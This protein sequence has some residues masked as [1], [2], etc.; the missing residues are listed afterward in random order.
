MSQIRRII[1]AALA[2]AACLAQPARAETSH[3]EQLWINL[4]AM[5]SIS[6]RAVYFVEFQPRIGDG[7]SRVDQLLM[8]AALGWKLSPGVSVYQ[9]YGH[10]VVPIEGGRD[11]NE[12]RSFQQL[13]LAMGKPLGGELSSRTRL[14][15][16]W[17]SN[18]RD[19]GW[20]LRSMVRFEKALRADSDAINALVWA[21]PFVALNDTD[22]GARAGFDQLRSFAGIEL[23]L[24][25]ASTAELGYL[26]QI[27]DQ[28]G[29]DRRMNHVASVTVFFR[30]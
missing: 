28:R 10:I 29:G 19:V 15:Q 17:R 23:G 20:R 8:R 25:G 2:C 11:V 6:E 3:D 21:E 13:N 14:E 26:N 22:W 16:R 4:T 24:P 1:A 7:V 5:G 12:E 30:P 27:V 9:G 18:G